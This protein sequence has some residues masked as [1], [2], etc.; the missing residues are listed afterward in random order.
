MVLNTNMYIRISYNKGTH[1]GL[2]NTDLYNAKKITD[3][4]KNTK[5]LFIYFVCT[6][7][8]NLLHLY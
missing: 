5:R 1:F 4:D 3:N 7:L 2:L 8:N 6:A